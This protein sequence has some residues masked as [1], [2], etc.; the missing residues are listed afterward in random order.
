MLRRWS[1]RRTVRNCATADVS[2]RAGVDAYLKSSLGD[3]PV[4]IDGAPIEDGKVGTMLVGCDEYYL[5]VYLEPLLRSIEHN[6]SEM[7][8]HLHVADASDSGI[9]YVHR[10]ASQTLGDLLSATFSKPDNLESLSYR[11][12]YYS[13]CRFL[14]LGEILRRTGQPVFS[15]DVDA[16]VMRPVWPTL[17]QHLNGADVVI[18]RRDARR[19]EKRV[20]AGAVA[21]A[22]TELGRRF[23]S[24][25]ACA[26]LKLLETRPRYHVDQITLGYLID[27]MEPMGLRVAQMPTSLID[28][29]FDADSIIW[30]AK[31]GRKDDA[32]FRAAA[33]AILQ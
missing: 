20:L 4:V 13:A 6:D 11:Q 17:S 29:E 25:L 10:L 8:L 15:I 21:V 1:I 27:T 14:I 31:G 5:Q 24:N 28:F 9:S 7:R 22:P 26:L 33:S 19:A 3:Y 12:I 32:K 2:D 16:V 23:A 18:F 30:T